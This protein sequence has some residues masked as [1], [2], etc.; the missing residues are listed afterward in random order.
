MLTPSVSGIMH[1]MADQSEAFAAVTIMTRK[2]TVTWRK[3]RLHRNELP[4]RARLSG[5]APD[6][7]ERDAASEFGSTAFDIHL[8]GEECCRGEGTAPCM[9]AG[10]EKIANRGGRHV[11]EDVQIKWR[12]TRSLKPRRQS[13]PFEEI[14]KRVERADNGAG[15]Q[16]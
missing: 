11:G 16:A 5:M 7:W 8:G 13:E 2:A 14:R 1:L 10:G 15:R 3:R 9:V 12:H 6:V 4:L